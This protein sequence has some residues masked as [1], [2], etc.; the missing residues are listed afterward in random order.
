MINEQ[1]YVYKYDIYF[2]RK[3]VFSKNIFVY[4]SSVCVCYWMYC[5]H[6]VRAISIS[7]PMWHLSHISGLFSSFTSFICRSWN[8]WAS[9]KPFRLFFD[10]SNNCKKCVTILYIFYTF[11]H[12]KCKTML[13]LSLKNVGWTTKNVIY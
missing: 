5:I 1:H 4:I 6:T 11:T 12:T 3:T 7:A 13:T 8:T 9:L 2:S 10:K